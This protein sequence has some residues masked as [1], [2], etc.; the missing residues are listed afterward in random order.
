VTQPRPLTV[1]TYLTTFDSL[2]FGHGMRIVAGY[3]HHE[4][5]ALR[6]FPRA[7]PSG[8][9]RLTAT[10]LPFFRSIG[11][12]A[13]RRTFLT[14]LG[15]GVA[16]Y[17]LAPFCWLLLTSFMH[18]KDTLSV[19]RQ[20]I[21]KHPDSSNSLTFFDPSGDAALVGSRAAAERCLGW[22][23]SLLAATGTAVLNLVFDA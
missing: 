15:I 6:V 4:G 23:S 11:R 19:P 3:R 5:L 22:V 7:R 13:R 21:P 12:G 17:I 20:W 8:N 14:I 10:A 1:H 16:I 2:D 18:E 9:I